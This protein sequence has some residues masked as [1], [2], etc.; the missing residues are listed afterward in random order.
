[1]KRVIA[2][3]IDQLLE[4]D[5][6]DSYE[7]Y[8]KDLESKKQWFKVL[9]KNTLDDGWVEVRIQKQYNRHTWEGR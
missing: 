3:C 4:F 2:A 7:E 8:I 9:Y 6:E 1:M 5:S